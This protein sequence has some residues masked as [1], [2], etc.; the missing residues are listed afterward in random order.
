LFPCF[1][2]RSALTS[3]ASQRLLVAL[4]QDFS[5][6]LQLAEQCLDVRLP[7]ELAKLAE[8]LCRLGKSD[9]C[10]LAISESSRGPSA[11]HWNK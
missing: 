7:S 10:S 4:G 3:N 1:A 5:L 11:S 8:I 9:E 6:P 2:L